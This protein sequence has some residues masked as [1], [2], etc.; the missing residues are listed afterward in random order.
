MYGNGLQL[1]T[2]NRPQFAH[3]CT[4]CVFLGSHTHLGEMAD[5]TRERVKSDLYRC[6]DT[7]IAR[8]S[9][10]GSDY[11]SVPIDIVIQIRT[12]A[13]NGERMST[14]GPA[15]VEALYRVE[16]EE[17]DASQADSC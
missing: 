1:L 15:L 14:M 10:E 16:E 5:G 6:R 11:A 3:D 17:V 8:G 13:L 7:V 12:R 2:G 4:H 9:D